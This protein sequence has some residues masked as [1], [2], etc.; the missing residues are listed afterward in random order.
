MKDLVRLHFEEDT[1]VP[2]IVTSGEIYV[3]EYG[4]SYEI[5]DVA[6]DIAR[7]GYA[8]VYVRKGSLYVAP[9]DLFERAIADGHLEL[10]GHEE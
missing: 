6:K 4:V 3:D 7:G 2:T 9:V 10:W 8:I 5:L 1:N